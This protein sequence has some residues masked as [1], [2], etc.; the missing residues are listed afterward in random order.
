MSFKKELEEILDA[1]KNYAVESI[2][3]QP[4]NVSEQKINKRQA[5]TSIINLVDKDIIGET[6]DI[7]RRKTFAETQKEIKVR[8][9]LRAEQRNKLRDGE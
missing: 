5:L 1:Y 8:D 4:T 2:T 3:L 9:N 6:D 7:L